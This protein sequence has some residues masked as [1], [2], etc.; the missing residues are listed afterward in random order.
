MAKYI[1]SSKWEKFAARILY[2]ARI[3]F[4]IEREI[5]NFSNKQKLNEYSNP[6]PILKKNNNNGRAPLNKEEE[7]GW[8]TSQLEGNHLN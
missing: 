7:I 6:K 4:K 5:K 2:P 8:R 3:S 1:Q